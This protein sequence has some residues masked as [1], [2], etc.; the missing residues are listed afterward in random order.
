MATMNATR[1]LP[2]G[3]AMGDFV[4]VAMIIVGHVVEVY[5]D[6]I[7]AQLGDRHGLPVG[8]RHNLQGGDAWVEYLVALRMSR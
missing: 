2:V 5:V 4:G 3:I 8:A 7:A 6:G 1:F